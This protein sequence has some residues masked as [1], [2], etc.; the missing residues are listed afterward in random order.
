MTIQVLRTRGEKTGRGVTPKKRVAG[1]CRD[2][3][4]LTGK[5]I[6]IEGLLARG[7]LKRM[8]REA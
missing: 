7:Y 4:F 1:D 2:E 6:N 8:K 3:A 5:G